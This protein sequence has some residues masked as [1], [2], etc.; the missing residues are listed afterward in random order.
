MNHQAQTKSKDDDEKRLQKML[1]K[2][3]LEMNMQRANSRKD[4]HG[5]AGRACDIFCFFSVFGGLMKI[6]YYFSITYQSFSA[7]S[8]CEW[9]KIVRV[10]IG[11]M[12][13]LKRYTV[14]C[15]IFFECINNFIHSVS[16]YALISATLFK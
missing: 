6:V 11:F 15:K 8:Y 5:S 4:L 14:N 13:F 9:I 3:Q 7:M 10:S 1:E 12:M 2:Y 16:H